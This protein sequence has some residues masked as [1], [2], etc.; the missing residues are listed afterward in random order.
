MFR[1]MLN[2]IIRERRHCEITVIVPVLP[3]HIDLPFALGRLD[4]VLREQLSLFIGMIFRTLKLREEGEIS[5]AF[6]EPLVF[7][8]A[9]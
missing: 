7:T 9:N 3:P 5:L 2:M 6:R 1:R 4:K 8:T